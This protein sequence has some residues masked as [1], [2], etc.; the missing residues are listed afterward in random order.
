MTQS[1]SQKIRNP[2]PPS[3]L[4]AVLAAGLVVGISTASIVISF[5]VLIFSGELAGFVSRGIGLFLFGSLIA[6]IITGLASSYA[7]MISIN[8]DVPAAIIAV[9]ATG[10]VGSMA[11]AATPDA[12]YLSVVA[13]III[14][15]LLTGLVFILQG[16]FKLGALFRF[17]PYPVVGGFLAGT[18]WLLV[19]GGMTVMTGPLAGSGQLAAL[20]EPDMLIRWLPG[21]A[22]AVAMLMIVQRFN[23]FLIMPGMILGA[24]GLF[25]LF[26]W[27][28]DIPI[29]HIRDQGWLLGPFPAGGLWQ[30]FPPSA[31]FHVAWPAIF[32][33]AGNIAAILT[34]STIALLLNTSGL[35]LMV[36]RDIQLDREL[37]ANGLGTLGA[38]LVGGL[39]SYSALSLSILGHRIGGSSR[40]TSLVVAAVLGIIL[41]FGPDMLS[42]T[43]KMV[44]GGLLMFLGLSLLNEWVY[45]AWFKFSRIDYLII[46]IILIVIGM[47]GFLQGVVLGVVLAVGLFVVNYSRVSVIKHAF[48]GVQYPSRVTRLRAH[49]Q[50][51]E[52]KA[53]EIYILQLQSFIFFGTANNLLHHVRQRIEAIDLPRLRFVVFDF[54]QVTG[55]DSTAMLS[56]TK[57]I[58]LAQSQQMVLVF[59]NPSAENMLPGQDGSVARFFARLSRIE[60]EDETSVCIFPDLDRGLEWCE[61]Q[62]LLA[63]GINLNDD[64]ES[65]RAHLGSLLPDTANLDHI[66]RYFERLEVHTGYYLMNQGDPPQ[67]L[68]FIESGQVTAQLEF[69]DRS[70]VRL[71]TMR[72]GRVV[73]EIGFYLNK[74]RT[75]AV[76]ADEPSTLY[77][78][79]TQALRQMER[80]DPE[81]ASAFHQGIIRLVSERLTHLITTVHALQ[82]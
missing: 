30:P 47:V 73:G 79:S 63:A 31:V 38:G 35:E 60:Q 80:D 29:G 10:I 50:L 54:R 9:M 72:G 67:D 3:Q 57:L 44:F 64:H 56:F 5:A 4:L 77:R 1:A 49:R 37:Q 62:L 71:E 51:L 33:Q 11:S 12:I 14:T 28:L 7:G 43:P 65:L 2:T 66:L 69:P 74:P 48:S 76:V 42:W 15:S 19:S 13:A 25:H 8:Q 75:A 21:A 68:Y 45:H 40:L 59:T 81:A 70:P 22:F 23:H 36:K 55:L 61:N 24:A 78:L 32:A 26:V 52:Q 39:V 16:Y 17:L 34:V 27:L 82:Q 6:T 20:V 41:Y 53:D 46:I 18:G 58:Q